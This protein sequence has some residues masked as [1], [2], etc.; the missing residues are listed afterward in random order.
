M[1]R[2]VRFEYKGIQFATVKDNTFIAT[3]FV[4]HSDSHRLMDM[5]YAMN[6][7]AMWMSKIP[8]TDFSLNLTRTGRVYL[9]ILNEDSA[10]EFVNLIDLDPKKKKKFFKDMEKKKKIFYESRQGITTNIP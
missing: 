3:K 5:H 8:S 2:H 4:L 1:E 9:Y 10:V 7:L 6:D